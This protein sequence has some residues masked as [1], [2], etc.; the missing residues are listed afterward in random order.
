MG[1]MVR[2]P[3]CEV[4]VRELGFG[5]P[6]CGACVADRFFS[7][8]HR[9]KYDKKRPA[10]CWVAHA[11]LT[12]LECLRL[13]PRL[14]GALRRLKIPWSDIEVLAILHDAGKLTECYAKGI[15]GHSVFSMVIVANICGYRS[16]LARAAFLHHEAF[17]WA[18][19]A[20]RGLEHI[21]DAI[22]S[23][24]SKIASNGFNLRKGHDEAVECLK[25]LLHSAGLRQ[26]DDILDELSSRRKYSLNCKPDELISYID[27]KDIAMYWILYLA[28]N[29][30]ASARDGPKGYWLYRIREI[31]SSH[32]DPLDLT[33]KLLNE[34]PRPNIALT[35]LQV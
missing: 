24:Q 18:R 10:G 16:R 27:A 9:R 11:A 22:S 26:M 29:R 34:Y 6:P 35:A 32:Q 2:I 7:F 21:A 8:W 31:M 14:E 19:V 4:L 12:L 23:N 3:E 28:D 5:K 17:H 20:K 33:D 25:A 1:K 30:A 15:P 13:R